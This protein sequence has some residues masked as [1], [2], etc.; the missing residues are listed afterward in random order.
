MG[1]TAALVLPVII[2]SLPVTPSGVQSHV[3]KAT[4]E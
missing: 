2:T 4:L 3:V 1:L